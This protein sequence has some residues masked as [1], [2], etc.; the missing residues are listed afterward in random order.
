MAA[1][2]ILPHACSFN[3]ESEPTVVPASTTSCASWVLKAGVLPRQ[4]IGPEQPRAKWRIKIPCW[5]CWISCFIRFYNALYTVYTCL[6][7]IRVYHVTIPAETLG[8]IMKKSGN[9]TTS[10]R[11]TNQG[12]DVR[13]TVSRAC[14]P[15]RLATST[16]P[17]CWKVPYSVPNLMV[18]NA[19]AWCMLSWSLWVT[20]SWQSGYLY[21]Y[22]YTYMCIYIYTYVCIYIYICTCECIYIH[23]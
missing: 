10:H 17:W 21:I 19:S 4:W 11:F 13:S 20:R 22:I 16:G 18:L 8:R 23:K 6:Y 5:S 7:I 1:C 2:H 15:R 9:P 14:L 12:P 3:G